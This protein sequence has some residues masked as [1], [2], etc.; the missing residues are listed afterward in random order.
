MLQCSIY[1][2]ILSNFDQYIHGVVNP[3]HTI[4]ALFHFKPDP[5][6]L[7]DLEKTRLCKDLVDQD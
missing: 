7:I 3:V 6:L 4:K 1:F 5:A 2:Y